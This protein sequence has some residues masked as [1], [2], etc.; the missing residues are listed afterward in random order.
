MPSAGPNSDKFYFSRPLHG[1]LAWVCDPSH[2]HHRCHH[3]YNSPPPQ[4]LSWMN[5]KTRPSRSSATT[6]STP[7][8]AALLLQ[9]R[10]DTLTFLFASLQQSHLQH[11]IFN[12][13]IINNRIINDRII[14]TQSSRVVASA[15]SPE[16]VEQAKNT[17]CGIRTS[18][19]VL[20]LFPT[21][22]YLA[23]HRADV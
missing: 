20:S 8:I 3:A 7:T 15:R 21:S 13:H 9:P 17:V 19:N 6:C 1:P 4:E 14:N 11:R 10:H 5:P 16:S 23:K 22:S 12:N 18:S 2:Y